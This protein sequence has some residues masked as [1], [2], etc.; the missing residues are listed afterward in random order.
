MMVYLYALLVCRL[1]CRVFVLPSDDK[2]TGSYVLILGLSTDLYTSRDD[3]IYVN[4]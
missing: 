3:Y 1:A 2:E 4:V